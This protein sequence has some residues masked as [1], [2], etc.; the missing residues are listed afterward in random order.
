LLAKRILSCHNFAHVGLFAPLATGLAEGSGI[1][2]RDVRRRCIDYRLPFSFNLVHSCYD[3]C[4]FS[5]DNV[6]VLPGAS[7]R[8]QLALKFV[9]SCDE[10]TE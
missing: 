2:M 7:Q 6:V 3:L 10:W 9:L 4:E 8:F 5:C 1:C